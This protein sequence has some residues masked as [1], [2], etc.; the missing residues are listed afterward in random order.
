MKTIGEM[1][2]A[3]DITKRQSSKIRN[4][5]SSLSHAQGA[6]K[7]AEENRLSRLPSPRP[8]PQSSQK[9]DGGAWV[10]EARHGSRLRK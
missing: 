1:A 9:N 7:E 2:K 4:G 3:H 8:Q 6:A 10:R 5:K